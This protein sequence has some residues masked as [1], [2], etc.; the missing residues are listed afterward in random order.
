[1]FDGW[2]PVL[3]MKKQNLGHFRSAIHPGR[4]PRS[5][6]VLWAAMSILVSS[7]ASAATLC[8]NPADS[9]VCSTTISAAVAIAAAGDTIKVAKG[10]YPEDVVINKTLSLIGAN[11]KTTIIDATGLATGIHIDGLDN[12]GLVDGSLVS[13]FTI[14]N[15]NFEG[16]L[17]TNASSVTVTEN[18]LSGNDKNLVLSAPPTCP[19]IPTFET[20]EGFDCGEAIHLLGADHA[21]VSNNLVEKNAGGILISDDTA[22]AHDNLVEG[23]TVKNN[24]FDCGITLASHKPATGLMPFGVMHNT[25][26]GNLSSAN[27]LGLM[28]EG[29]GVGIFDSVPNTIN[30]GNVVINNTLTKNGLPGVTMHSHTTGQF[31]NDN[32]I[33]DN[34]ISG[35]GADSSNGT[36]VPTGINLSGVSDATGT[37]IVGNVIKD[38]SVDVAINTGARADVHL[39]N[40]MGKGVGVTNSSSAI[41]DAID[42]FWGCAKGPGAKGCSTFSTPSTGSVLTT[43]FA[44]KPF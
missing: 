42:N 10:T 27:G 15:A 31:L 40:L 22:A 28:G 9:G 14:K 11:Q 6:A 34:S 20:N 8:V 36:S 12:P 7:S 4:A 38:E 39:N 26:V 24:P 25:I 1:M 16:I 33:I 18:Q 44:T 41:T 2:H 23:N 32:Q 37:V 13:G 5:T 29:A 17:I 3:T 21:I 43:P 19:G 35:N 30:S